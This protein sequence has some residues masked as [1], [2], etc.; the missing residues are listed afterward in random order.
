[1]AFRLWKRPSFSMP[2][3]PSNAFFSILYWRYTEHQPNLDEKKGIATTSKTEIR[4]RERTLCHVSVR[5]L[6]KLTIKLFDLFTQL[7]KANKKGIRLESKLFLLSTST[8]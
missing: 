1:M 8:K 5:T 7:V 4:R 3:H 6:N 2:G